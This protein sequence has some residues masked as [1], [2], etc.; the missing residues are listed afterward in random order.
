MK[1][2]LRLGYIGF[3]A[4]TPGVLF[5]IVSLSAT[6]ALAAPQ[7]D[8]QCDDC[9]TMPPLDSASGERDPATGAFKGNHQGHASS[10]A[11]SCARC[12]GAAVL[13]YATGHR[14]K[15]IQV[16][17][18]INNSPLG[19]SYSRTFFNQTSVLPQVLGTCSNVN[20]HFES[21]TPSWGSSLFAGTGDCARCHGA[22]PSTG[23][24][25]VAGSKHG[26]YYGLGTGS[27]LK[28]HADHLGEAKPFAHATSAGHRGISVSFST[29]PNSGGSYSGSGLGFLP[30]Q[31]K[32]SFGSCS[33]L[34]CHSNGTGGAPNVVPAWGGSL[35]CKGCHN[36]N[37]A[38]GTPM[39]SGK[40]GAH[41]N[42]SAVLG[43]NFGCAECHAR[44]VQNDSAISDV[45]RHVN[46]FVD[47]S[48]ARS[49]KTYSSATGVCSTVYCHSDGKGSYKDLT[50]TGWKS[51]ATLD[52]KG[53][54][55][56]AAV[57]AFSSVAGEPNYANGG[58]G[59]PRANTHQAHVSGAG[60]CYKCH[61][62]TV[63]STGKLTGS[64]HTN[65]SIDVA[66]NAGSAGPA[67]TWT[68]GTKTCSGL[69][70]HS[71]G[72]G[73]APNVVPT[74]GT[75]LDCKGCH[76]SNAASGA[77]M[78]SGKHGAHVNN[79]ATLGANYGCVE[80]HAKTVQ[81]DST[82]SD[83][84][85]HANGFVDF[86]GARSGRSY[87]SA[88]GVCS[89]VY[90]H[91][92]GKG[93]YKDMTLTGWKSA[94]TLDCKGCHGSAA[95]PAFTSVAGEP[96]YANAGVG[97]SRANTHQPHV[98]AA[99]D[100]SNCHT[101][102]VD[103]TGK[104]TGTGHTNGSIEVNFKSSSAGPGATWTKNTGT[105]SLIT[106]HSD[107]TSVATGATS[108]GT[109]TWGTTAAFGCSACHGN[110]PA[111]AN[112]APKANSH[113]SH[114]F[115]CGSC[116]AGT[117]SDGV[118]ISGPALHANGVYNVIPGSGAAF[119]YTFANSGGTCSSVNCHAGV[120]AKWGETANHT[121]ILTSGDIAMFSDTDHHDDGQE[122]V[123]EQCAL[124]HVANIVAQHNNDCTICHSGTTPPAAG[125]LKIGGH[126]DQNCQSGSCHPTMHTQM[127]HGAVVALN[128]YDQCN[129]CHSIDDPW[130]VDYGT[131]TGDNCAWC[132]S[133]QQTLSLFQ[134]QHPPY[135]DT[136]PSAI[137]GNLKL[138]MHMDEPAWNGTAGEVKDSSGW[139]NHGKA[140]T[141]ATTV[142]G[143]K[144]GRAGS[145]DGTGNVS[146]AYASGTVPMDNFTL[147][148]W[149]K[150]TK[151]YLPDL[152]STSGVAGAYSFPK[153]LFLP[154][155]RGAVDSGAGVSVATNGIS[156]YEYGDGYLPALSVYNGAISSSQWTHLAVVYENKRPSIYVNGVLVHTGLTS[157]RQH[158]YAPQT[159]G[160]A[161]FGWYYGF[162]DEIA[163]YG[164]ALTVA[165]ILQHVQKLCTDT[166]NTAI[167]GISW[168]SAI[169]SSSYVDYGLTASYGT[170]I[171][172]DAL[173]N[174]HI[175][176]L[177]G[178]TSNTYHYRVRSTTSN[179]IETVS[180][181][182]TFT[183]N[184]NSC[185]AP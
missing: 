94:A 15:A 160:G 67:A 130:S 131:V 164:S 22:A 173:V 56:S 151:T 180:A 69:I 123:H 157:P 68:G 182:Y 30:S 18:N 63:D 114:A 115:A 6:L 80:C 10:D 155:G 65:G 61:V 106:C 54:H 35:D 36:S 107:G 162:A 92:D 72:T 96:N 144:I 41:M 117:T 84:S 101:G 113:G 8:V 137:K 136:P 149:I 175:V 110:P 62:N 53:C 1:S 125:V 165:D 178:L 169:A 76:N 127:A 156:V 75:V 97:L 139:N 21:L 39:T 158:V 49:G 17:G 174:K 79:T 34:Y 2:Y 100:C 147:E 74:W 140:S 59:Q 184:F 141:G 52:C 89:T 176:P 168:N 28:C 77:P 3:R 51:A 133:P 71:N 185:A 37:A 119:S 145:F 31:N 23:S 88:T 85:R 154:D 167:S 129:K 4:I 7:Y 48:G 33:N 90:C 93:S 64:A 14:T 57:P 5:G 170:T 87:I 142:A 116:H 102:T 91:S 183:N 43:T 181:D 44:T 143:G 73:G 134:S 58:A 13:N 27:C 25:P 16:Q 11:A 111:Y 99:T 124:C 19:G 55:G 161:Y 42:N 103:S 150:P 40:H 177:P 138:L 105:C 126:W 146:F 122:I 26:A 66:F 9:H 132:H 47:F 108:G 50:L 153:F 135:V 45:S 148:A 159:I 120:V 172:N 104:L 32:V 98:K 24:H 121:A 12:H 112:H 83:T 38:S 20:C 29:T 128:D 171:G 46:G 81:N 118:T 152:E 166:S 82:I 60:D 70:C 109:M 163:V 95:V 179:S 86:S 78:T